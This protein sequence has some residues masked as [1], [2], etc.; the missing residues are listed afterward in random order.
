MARETLRA[1]PGE[2][3]WETTTDGRVWVSQ[4][5][6]RGHTRETSVGGK[7]GSRL[8]ISTIDREI[9]Q[10]RVMGPDPFTNGM[11]RRVDADQ[12]TDPRTASDDVLSTEDLMVGFSKSGNAFR[13]YVDRLSEFNVRRMHEMAEMVDASQSQVTYLR[14]VITDRFRQEGDTPTYREMRQVGDV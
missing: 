9:C 10:D 3:I 13:S 2:E 8:R 4:T 11:L 6:E 12:A 1:R 14:T 7:A 5:D